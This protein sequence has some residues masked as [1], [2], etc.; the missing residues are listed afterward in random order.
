MDGL[1]L[2]LVR[3]AVEDQPTEDLPDL[4]AA[5]LAAGSDT[6]A[7]RELAG[8]PRSDVR[9]AR[10]LFL[11]AVEELGWRVPTEDEARRQL[12]RHWA[13]E[14]LA[15]RLTPYEASSLIWWKAANPLGKP[16]DLIIFVGLASEWQDLPQY[17]REL[18]ARMIEE[19]RKLVDAPST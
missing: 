17:R 12:A 16:D 11:Q 1:R 10:D 8:T 5:A 6:P 4:A 15:G 9:A 14:M 18:E 13:G 3:L 2:A 19:A 7:L